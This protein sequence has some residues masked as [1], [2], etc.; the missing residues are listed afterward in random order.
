MPTIS[1]R[2]AECGYRPELTPAWVAIMSG[3]THEPNLSREEA[4]KLLVPVVVSVLVA[5][6][7]IVTDLA[8]RRLRRPGANSHSSPSRGVAVDGGY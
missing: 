3:F 5:M 4:L 6:Y 7:L 8:S 1:E 2:D